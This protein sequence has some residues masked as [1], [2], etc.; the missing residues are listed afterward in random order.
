MESSSFSPSA[1][2][3][4]EDL[5]RRF[6]LFSKQHWY[7]EAADVGRQWLEKSKS[8]WGP[9]HPDTLSIMYLRGTALYADGK[10][11]DAEEIFRELLSLRKEKLGLDH[12]DTIATLDAVCET[13][14]GL[15]KYDE[16]MRLLEEELRLCENAFGLQHE[17]TIKTLRNAAQMY[18]MKN[19]PF[20]ASAVLLRALEL[21]TK[22]FGRD[23]P[24]TAGIQDELNEIRGPQD[25]LALRQ[26]LAAKNGLPIPGDLLS[27]LKSIDISQLL[28]EYQDVSGF[29]SGGVELT[30]AS[31]MRL[32]EVRGIL[33]QPALRIPSA[34]ESETSED[35]SLSESEF[36]SHA[37]E[38]PM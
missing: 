20:L 3:E 13:L 25:S 8:V 11:D 7:A 22:G 26:A 18:R 6:Q 34:F 4:V 1:D 28:A 21:S 30:N 35:E 10:L 32:G 19:D 29:V 33:P 38:I 31:M 24:C 23:H 36:Q 17:L 15:C 27:G 9:N 14:C 12:R 37:D 5:H 2:K 16:S